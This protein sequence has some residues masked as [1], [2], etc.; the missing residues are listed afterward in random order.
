MEV[1]RLPRGSR[2]STQ[3]IAIGVAVGDTFTELIHRVSPPFT[4]Y[5]IIVSVT[6]RAK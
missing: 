2:N 1:Q 3:V 6:L 4:A 5:D